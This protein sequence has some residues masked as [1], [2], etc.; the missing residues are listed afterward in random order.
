M[1]TSWLHLISLAAFLGSVI[2]L[3]LV[4]LPS[5]SVIKSHEGQLKLLA[6]SLKLYN[7]LQTGALGLLVLSGAFQITE[8]KATY[9]ELFIKQLGVML[10]LK[11]ALSFVLIVLSTYQSMAVAHRFVRRYEGGEAL[12]PQDLQLVA[13]RLRISTHAIL[14]LAFMTALVGVWMRGS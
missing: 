6:R 4:L 8:L 5:L 1:L 9:R 7:P 10:A 13:R 12:S 2:G 3:W 11:L 14:L